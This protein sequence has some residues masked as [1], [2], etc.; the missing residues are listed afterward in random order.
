MECEGSESPDTV[1]RGHTM[2]GAQVQVEM[3]SL[4]FTIRT[5]LYVT[6]L[7]ALVCAVYAT[8]QARRRSSEHAVAQL[9]DA[10]SAKGGY[11]SED[12]V[13]GGL[14]LYLRNASLTDAD[15]ARMKVLWQK[16]LSSDLGAACEV[17]L[18]LT[19]AEL[20]GDI[21]KNLNE[22]VCQLNLTGVDVNDSSL[23]KIVK[24]CPRLHTLILDGTTISDHSMKT[25]AMLPIRFLSIRNTTITLD[26]LVQLRDCSLLYE[27]A[28]SEDMLSDHELKSIKKVLP[29]CVVDRGQ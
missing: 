8:W 27:L 25:V 24:T 23:E 18:D 22:Q 19:N 14:L 21:A 7:L 26:G 13:D 5:L 1:N 2:A 29:G 28:V 17:A 11:L 6:T 20:E 3:I 9:M 4:R 15:L 16:C 12:L 10:C